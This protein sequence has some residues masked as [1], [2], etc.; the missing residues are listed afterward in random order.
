ML[1]QQKKERIGKKSGW[2]KTDV[3]RHETSPYCIYWI[4]CGGLCAKIL[5]FFL[6]VTIRREGFIHIPE[7]PLL[8]AKPVSQFL[9]IHFLHVTPLEF[10]QKRLLSS[11]LQNFASLWTFFI[12]LNFHFK[13]LHIPN[14]TL[15]LT[16]HEDG[17]T[18]IMQ[19]LKWK[20]FQSWGVR[21]ITKLFSIGL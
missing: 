12:S 6:V 15:Q 14:S 17:H 16:R 20:G 19:T 4:F 2:H 11:D 3:L 10:T 18:N 8:M 7:L 13:H 21:Y 9:S 1:K 5:F